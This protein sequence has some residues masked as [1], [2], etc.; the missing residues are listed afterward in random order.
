MLDHPGCTGVVA[1]RDKASQVRNSRRD[2]RLVICDE[3]VASIC[4][5]FGGKKLVVIDYLGIGAKT[6][7][8][9]QGLSNFN[10]PDDRSHSGVADDC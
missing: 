1:R 10:A 3:D 6:G 4:E 2:L 9:Q 8:D 5:T 7:H